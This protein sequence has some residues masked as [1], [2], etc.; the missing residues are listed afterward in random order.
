MTSPSTDI[1][2]MCQGKGEHDLLPPNGEYYVTLSWHQMR[3][4]PE[5]E[6]WE[7]KQSEVPVPASSWRRAW[8]PADFIPLLLNVFYRRG[9]RF[10]GSLPSIKDLSEISAQSINIPMF[11]FEWR[12]L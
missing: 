2:P 3:G 10:V 7:K 12:W 9:Y 1:C 5:Y 6:E 11:A 4:L 8:S